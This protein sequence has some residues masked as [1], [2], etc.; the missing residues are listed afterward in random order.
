MYVWPFPV[1]FNPV[2]FILVTLS[3]KKIKANFKLN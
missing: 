3:I 1:V 2:P